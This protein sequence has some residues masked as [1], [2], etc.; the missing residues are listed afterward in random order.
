MSFDTRDRFERSSVQLAAGDR[1]VCE[2]GAEK[3][4]GRRGREGRGGGG[5]KTTKGAKER[6]RRGEEE[7]RPWLLVLLE[8][9][10]ENTGRNKVVGAD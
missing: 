3:E 7:E 8:R 1:S 10:T 2:C 5:Q 6:L 9:T 4:N